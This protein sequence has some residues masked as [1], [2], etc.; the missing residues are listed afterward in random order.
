MQTTSSNGGFYLKKAASGRIWREQDISMAI[1]IAGVY[2]A[3]ETI[4]LKESSL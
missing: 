1:C 2:L 4:A 3:L